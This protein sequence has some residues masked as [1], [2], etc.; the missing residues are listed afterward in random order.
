L[1]QPPEAPK[2]YR[3]VWNPAKRNWELEAIPGSPAYR[4]QQEQDTSQLQVANRGIQSIDRALAL[5][6]PWSTGW[7]GARLKGVE[8]SPAFNLSAELIQLQALTSFAEL[9]KM[10]AAS[11]TG[12]ALGAVS[13]TEGKKLESTMASLQ[14]GQSKPKL[15]AALLRLREEYLDA[16]YGSKEKLTKLVQ[17]GKISQRVFDS[18][19]ALKARATPGTPAGEPTNTKSLGGKTYKSYDNGKTW[20]TD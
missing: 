17:E 5:S 3:P 9:Q 10:R 15:D 2:D 4:A 8:G 12:A 14:Q 7:T 16:V 6:T 1:P 20:W 19:E 11:P 13:D 18:V